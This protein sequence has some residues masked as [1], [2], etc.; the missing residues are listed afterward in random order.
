LFVCLSAEAQDIARL[1]LPGD[2]AFQLM[3]GNPLS[4]IEAGAGSKLFVRYNSRF[5]DY[6]HEQRRD[7]SSP[8]LGGAVHSIKAGVAFPSGS[9]LN[10][11]GQSEYLT[12][13]ARSSSDQL[14]DYSNNRKFLGLAYGMPLSPG[15]RW[16]VNVG[17]SDA[18]GSVL[19]D[20][21][22]AVS[23]SLPNGALSIGLE[24]TTNAQQMGVIVSSIRGTLPLNHQNII[25]RVAVTTG[26]ESVRFSF[27]ASQTVVSPHHDQS[28]PDGLRFEP[29]GYVRQWQSRMEAGLNGS[30]KMV[31][32][33][34]G[35]VFQGRGAFTANGSGY[36]MLERAD[37]E[38]TSVSGGLVHESAGLMFVSDLS[39]TRIDGSLD[40]R[41]ESWPFVSLLQSPFSQRANFDIE[42]TFRL[43]NAHT[44]AIVKLTDWL[45]MGGGISVLRLIPDLRIES[46]QA[47]FL[48][49]GRKAYTD[50]R[51]SVE[52]L[53]GGMIS[54]GFQ[55][56]LGDVG[57]DYSVN[58]F[59]PINLQ[60]TSLPSGTSGIFTAPQAGTVVKSWGGLFQRVSVKWG[61]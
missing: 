53:D 58:Q 23:F 7:G 46:W 12:S 56:R 36:G 2:P 3:G 31:L 41:I 48:G 27:A 4:I 8:S 39:W 1:F 6:Y 44:G 29:A 20:I 59:V 57:I 60:K 15:L 40:G 11:I 38:E 33:A 49:I 35:N 47:G 28:H 10:L 30:W 21:G 16:T 45:N 13:Q 54:A 43:L 52:Q 34:E 42:G 37:Y 9:T 32:T 24:R 26:S 5:D 17:Y 51:L 18:S 61:M 55:M 19:Q 22:T 25:S 50:R 14:M